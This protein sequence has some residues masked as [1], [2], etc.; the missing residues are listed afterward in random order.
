MQTIPYFLQDTANS[1][2][3]SLINKPVTFN[4]FK[5]EFL[6]YF[7]NNNNINQ[8]INTFTTIKQGEAEAITI[9]L[10]SSIF[11]CVHLLHSANL[12]AAVNNARDF[13]AAE[14]KANHV[15]AINLVM[16]RLSELDSKLKQ[17]RNTTCFQNQSHSLSSSNQPWQSEM[18]VCHN[19]GKQGHIQKI[20]TETSIADFRPKLLPKSRSISIYL[21]ANDAAA[22]LSTTNISS[23]NL[24]ATATNN[25][26]TIN[27]QAENDTTKLEIGDGSSPTN[28]QFIQPTFKIMPVDFQNYLSFLVTP[29]DTSSNNLET[30]QKNLTSNIPSATVTNNESLVTIFSFEFEELSFMPLF[31]GAV[32]E[33]KPITIM[34]TDAK[35]DG[36]SIKLILDSR[37][38]GSII[39]RQLID[40]LGCQVDRAV[41]ARIIT[42]Y[43][44]TKTLIALVSNDWLFKTNVTLDWTTQELQIIPATC[45][46]FKPSNVMPTLLI[47]VE[48]KKPK[49]TWEAY[50]VSWTNNNHNKLSLILTWNEK[51]K[52]KQKEELTWNANQTWET[53]NSSNK[54][55]I[56]EWEET[57]KKKEKRKKE[58]L[59]EETT[60]TEK[61]T[62]GWE[63]E[64]LWEPIK[65]L[66]YIPLKCKDCG[67]KLSFMGAW[68]NIDTQNV[69]ESG[70]TNHVS[71]VANKRTCD[72]LCQYTILINDWRNTSGNCKNSLREN[73]KQQDKIWH[74]ANAKVKKVMP[75]KILKIKNNPSESVNIVLIS[76]PKAFLDIETSS[77]KFHEH[78]QNLALTR[79][80]QEQWLKK[81]NTR[82]CDYCLIPCDF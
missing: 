17:F 73:L 77:E 16:N 43:G 5:T 74:M 46:H 69:K 32:L 50:Q 54:L 39:T 9:G 65:E 56:W 21:P 72:A 20:N 42:A 63:R 38:A 25:I 68:N 22:N 53:N 57:N 61:I 59:P 7:S 1:W 49:P 24:L 14:L 11:Q 44:A 66:P 80:K 75:S 33:E 58:D 28:F 40:Q 34:Y 30:N 67:K 26:S 60:I 62:S 6:R 15:Q 12:Q 35:I 47:N 41:S 70:T 2:Y 13:E 78:Y 55:P 4:V 81:I 64:Y 82:L 36:H 29:E 3:Q 19:C 76:N 10:H 71:L 51:R 52:R 18:R 48:K 37:L 27:S 45:G 31:N 23:S 79:E 8:L